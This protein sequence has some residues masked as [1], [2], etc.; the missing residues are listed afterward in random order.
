MK[1]MYTASLKNNILLVA[2]F[3]IST[4]TIYSVESYLTAKEKA[5]DRLFRTGQ[6]VEVNYFAFVKNGFTLNSNN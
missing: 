1:T 5:Q 2:A 4:F 3:V 6:K